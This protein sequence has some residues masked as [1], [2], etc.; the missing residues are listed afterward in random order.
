MI[1]FLEAV[2]SDILIQHLGTSLIWSYE[3][4]ISLGEVLFPIDAFGWMILGRIPNQ[5]LSLL[6][7][8]LM[9]LIIGLIYSLPMLCLTCILYTVCVGIKAIILDKWTLAV[10]V[11]LLGAMIFG[12]D[13][14]TTYVNINISVLYIALMTIFCLIKVFISQNEIRFERI[15]PLKPLAKLF[16]GTLIF[17]F[18]IRILVYQCNY[19][20]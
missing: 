9:Y 14:I 4:L 15:Q 16:V 11:F 8:S 2:Q 3:K 20:Y 7:Y 18:F 6:V 1:T 10:S 5:V 13:I 17:Q 19:Y 12:M